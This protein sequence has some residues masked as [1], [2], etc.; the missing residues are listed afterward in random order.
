[1]GRAGKRLVGLG[2]LCLLVGVLT[3][4]AVAAADTV[5][6][7]PTIVSTTPS[8]TAVPTVAPVGETGSALTDLSAGHPP[9]TFAVATREPIPTGKGTVSKGKT[10]TVHVDRAMTALGRSVRVRADVQVPAN[11]KVTCYRATLHRQA[12]VKKLAS[13]SA[14]FFGSD[15]ALQEADAAFV[16]R[17]YAKGTVYRVTE[18][19]RQS[20]KLLAQDNGNAYSVVFANNAPWR[21]R[22][23]TGDWDK[24]QDQCQRL[25]SLL[26]SGEA[27]APQ[28]DRVVRPNGMKDE[29]VAT[30]TFAQCV[31]GWPIACGDGLPCFT[32][33]VVT[34]DW[35]HAGYYGL[36][37]KQGDVAALSASFHYDIGDSAGTVKILPLDDLLERLEEDGR[38]GAMVSSAGAQALYNTARLVYA[39]DRSQVSDDGSFVLKPYWE[40]VRIGSERQTFRFSA[41]PGDYE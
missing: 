10:K 24:A 34:R 38:V 29:P 7:E 16:G 1:M 9:V 31:D 40:L 15:I 26:F 21:Y 5:T 12:T 39:A 23:D 25:L 22:V 6:V 19:R 2:V 8:P 17:F 3:A 11:G 36:D 28:A 20:L 30:L 18:D 37:L 4:C 27:V 14:F 13:S 35:N 33:T 41:D 32:A